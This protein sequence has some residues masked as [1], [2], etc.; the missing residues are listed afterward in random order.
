MFQSDKSGAA[1]APMSLLEFPADLQRHILG[2]VPLRGMAQLAC[3]DKELR[4]VYLDRVEQRNAVVA[5]LLESHCTPD[6]RG[7]LSCMQTALPRDFI[8]EPSVRPLALCLLL[9]SRYTA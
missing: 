8:V 7:G 2:F 1:L 6:F 3:L 5:G 9:S 4:A